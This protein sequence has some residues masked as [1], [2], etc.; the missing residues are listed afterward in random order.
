[1]RVLLLIAAGVGAAVAGMVATILVAWTVATPVLFLGAGIV[2][3]IALW[4]LVG[5]ALTAS[6]PWLASG[7]IVV[8]AVLLSVLVPLG[9]PV[10]AP[11]LPPGAG[12]WSL[13]DG[14]SIAYGVVRADA[15]A[16]KRTPIVVL[17]GGPG[18]PDTAG[19]L[20]ALA[21]LAADGYDI[22]AYD[23]RGTGLSSRLSDPSGYTTQRAVDDLEQ[24]RLHV[25][26]PR[27]LLIGH[28]YGAYLAAAYVAAHG[29]RV[30][31]VV[32]SS[33]GDLDEAGL[34]GRPQSRLN[35]GQRLR[36]YS[37]LVAPRA[38]LTYALVQVNPAAAHS[39]VG[40]A[41]VDARQDRAYEAGLPALH[42]AGRALR[43]L[44]G[45]GF[46]ASQVPQSFRQPATPDVRSALTGTRPRGLII[47][48]QCDYLD[49][50]SAVDYVDTFPGS[51]LSYLPGA[52]HETYMDRPD[53]YV[54]AVRSFLAG[55]EVPGA[56]ANPR[57]VPEDYQP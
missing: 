15:D 13:P 19:F 27:L 11:P 56:L 35:V 1:V 3:A 22:W 48:G 43:P 5:R 14:G 55:T 49:W 39:F 36:L 32:F 18:V 34:G 28:S 10:V 53:A 8:A 21:P 54:Q 31:K 2:T 51:A 20:D 46:Y 50:Q 47:K 30:E 29:S 26:A 42:C 24:V 9:D 41:E 17:H 6:R 23:Q 16:S 57:Q 25:G 40:D 45:L 4:L 44:Y 52:G 38:L 33:P 7:G 37:L 12:R